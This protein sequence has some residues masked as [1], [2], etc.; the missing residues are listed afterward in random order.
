MKA[1]TALESRIT[2][3]RSADCNAPAAAQKESSLSEKCCL[4][5][6]PCRH[7]CVDHMCTGTSSSLSGVGAPKVN[8]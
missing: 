6:Q 3:S 8:P 1:D 2:C 4:T 5:N 7:V